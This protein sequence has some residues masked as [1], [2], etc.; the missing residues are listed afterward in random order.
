MP[1]FYTLILHFDR[2]I[3]KK[4]Q[5]YSQPLNIASLKF[6]IGFGVQCWHKNVIHDTELFITKHAL[7]GVTLK[8]TPFSNINIHVHWNNEKSGKAF[9]KSEV[10]RCKCY[11][12]CYRSM[13][14]LNHAEKWCLFPVS[15]SAI[16]FVFLCVVHPQELFIVSSA[17][18]ICCSS[19]AFTFIFDRV[20]WNCALSREPYEMEMEM[21]L[22]FQRI[23]S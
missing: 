22:K 18:H 4:T 8:Q 20:Y 14:A 10:T 11:C 15:W 6:S 12:S 17:T 23:N 13:E 19:Y 9:S 16:S 2:C 21:Y 7:E 1:E 3:L 5:V